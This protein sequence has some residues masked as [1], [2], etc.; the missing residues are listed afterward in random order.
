M[1]R[2]VDSNCYYYNSQGP[3]VILIGAVD[4][5]RSRQLCHEVFKETRNIIYI[6][7]GNGEYTGQVVCGVRK[8][9]RTITK[10]V[11]GI[12]LIFYR[13]MRNFRRS[14]RVLS[15]AYQRRRV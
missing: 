12:Y 15:E 4:N 8:N 1:E 7:S 6:D 9:G 3:T 13:A 11:A 5:N 10:P 14:F 2:L